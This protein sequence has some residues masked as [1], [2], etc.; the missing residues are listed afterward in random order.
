MGA[1]HC[2]HTALIDRARKLAGDTG[3]VVVSIFVNPTQFGPHEDFAKYPR[4]WQADAR[5]CRSHGV[6]AVFLPTADA[7]YAPD[8]SISIRENALSTVLCGA[9]RPGHFEG[10][11]T[12]VA[13]LFQLVGPDAAVFGEKDWQQLAIVRRMVRD[14]FLPV[15]IIGVP[16]VRAADGLALSSR[17]EFL[18][19]SARAVAPRIHSSLQETASSYAEGNLSPQALEANLRRKLRRIPGAE[20]D[21]AEIV[22]AAT[23]KKPLR[24]HCPGRALVA[25][26]LGGTRLI[27]NIALPPRHRNTKQNK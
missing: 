12:I 24:P 20:I 13:K 6:D 23:L 19:H 14:L 3:T 9:S 7:M 15:K 8:A 1:L 2:G 26:R 11:C 17:N 22:D 25:V 10:V 21:Y 5:L 18:D 27:D 16:T 4:L